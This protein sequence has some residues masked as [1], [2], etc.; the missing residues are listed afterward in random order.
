MTKISKN[1][2][3]E[4]KENLCMCYNDEQTKAVLDTK[5]NADKHKDDMNTYVCSIN[6]GVWDIYSCQLGIDVSLSKSCMK[7]EDTYVSMCIWQ[8]NLCA[9]GG[10]ISN[11]HIVV[12]GN[13]K[14][15]FLKFFT[16]GDTVSMTDKD[17][18][19]VQHDSKVDLD[20]QDLVDVVR[21]LETRNKK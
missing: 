7:F 18:E 5:K 19:S 8:G 15:W 10:S 4:Y 3:R 21:N 12:D 11:G 14:T 6:T 16:S 20:L 9:S 1:A 17:F 13:A 2:A